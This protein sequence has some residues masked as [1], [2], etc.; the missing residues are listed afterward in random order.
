MPLIERS[1]GFEAHDAGKRGIWG[2]MENK[3]AE[4]VWDLRLR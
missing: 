1:V 3:K 4:A 2:L